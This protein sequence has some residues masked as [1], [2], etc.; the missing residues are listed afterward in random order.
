[1]NLFCIETDFI[2]PF[3]FTLPTTIPL[4]MM[5]TPSHCEKL[6]SSAKISADIVTATGSSE[7][8]RIV[9]SPGP[10]WGIPIE[11]KSG[12]KATPNKPRNKP[13]GATPI[14]TGKSN[15]NIGGYTKSTTIKP[16]VDRKALFRT[17]GVSFPTELLRNIKVVKVKAESNP[18]AVPC[19]D[20]ATSLF[21]TKP[22]ARIE[23]IMRMPIEVIF[24]FVGFFL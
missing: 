20:R 14:K 17:G 13:Y 3:N 21:E 23:P 24:P 4:K 12:G 10:I 5:T 2:L 22:E 7:A 8:V 1:M 9:P 11:N 15:R 19:K 18:Q 16:P 6:T